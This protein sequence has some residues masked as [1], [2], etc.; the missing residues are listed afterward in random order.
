MVEVKIRWKREGTII[1]RNVSSSPLTRVRSRSGNMKGFLSLVGAWYRSRSLELWSWN[2]WLFVVEPTELIPLD[3]DRWEWMEVPWSAWFMM[4]CWDDI[5]LSTKCWCWSCDIVVWDNVPLTLIKSLSK[6]RW[7]RTW[8]FALFNSSFSAE[9]DCNLFSSPGG[10]RGIASFLSNI[11]LN[12]SSRKI[13]RTSIELHVS[14]NHQLKITKLSWI[15][16]A[17]YRLAWEG[18]RHAR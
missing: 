2:S 12:D 13:W 17:F 9:N 4:S 18:R 16:H 6:L 5:I 10:A 15:H 3:D 7:F 1:I 8:L 11:S 14:K